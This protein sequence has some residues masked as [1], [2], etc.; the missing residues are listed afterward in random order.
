VAIAP[1]NLPETATW[2]S[3]TATSQASSP[4]RRSIPQPGRAA[5]DLAW[6]VTPVLVPFCISQ[7][8]SFA[9]PRKRREVQQGGISSGSKAMESWPDVRPKH[10]Q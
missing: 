9:V 2:P 4:P 10:E 1:G 7:D 8:F 5:S 3:R 6:C